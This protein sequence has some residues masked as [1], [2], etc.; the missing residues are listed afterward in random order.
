MHSSLG[1]QSLT[2][3]EREFIT[4]TKAANDES[5]DHY[6]PS[7]RLMKRATKLLNEKSLESALTDAMPKKCFEEHARYTKKLQLPWH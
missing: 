6:S 3:L 4:N 2:E 1:Y 7:A 5:I